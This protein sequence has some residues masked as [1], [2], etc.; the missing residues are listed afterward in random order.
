MDAERLLDFS[1]S[2]AP[3]GADPWLPGFGPGTDLTIAD[4]DPAWARRGADLAS[5]ISVVLGAVALDVEHLGSTSVP[6]LPAKP[7]LDLVVTVADPDDE[8]SYVPALEVLGLV[9]V[10][11][12][13]WWYGHRLLRNADPRANVHVFGPDCS[14]TERMRLFRDWLR[15]HPEDRDRYARSK[16][17]AATGGGHVMDYNSRKQDVLREILTRA[18]RHSAQRPAH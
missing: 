16:R 1:A 3:P 17:A 9:H 5:E 15:T 8:A 2:E 6:D 12:E 10:V 18:V 7:I 14:E 11:R 4:P 13:P